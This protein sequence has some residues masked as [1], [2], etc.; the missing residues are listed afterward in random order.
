MSQLIKPAEGLRYYW[1]VQERL[2][3]LIGIVGGTGAMGSS[4]ALR[5]SS[6]GHRILLGSR[7][8]DKAREVAA[9]LADLQ[10]AGSGAI[11]GVT[12][13]EAAEG[14]MVFITAPFEGVQELVKELS[15]NLS[16]KVVVSLVNALVKVGSE[17]QP[18]TL[19][20][21][22]VAQSIQA[23]LP[24]SF[25]VSG[26]HHVAAKE[27]AKVDSPMDVDVL[28]CSDY[29]DGKDAVTG[30]LRAIPGIRILD[31]GSLS[32]SGAIEAMTA[33]LINLNIKYKTRTALRITGIKER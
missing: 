14:E 22:S 30:L 18:L 7:N 23:I 3:L 27:L 20:R 2:E 8:A 26:L 6:H 25:V 13:L 11:D 19:A 24:S 28:L 32:S 17:M 9:S 21:G 1:R 15:V 33:V 29:P 31:G 4:L 5:L 16:G 12:N 10:K